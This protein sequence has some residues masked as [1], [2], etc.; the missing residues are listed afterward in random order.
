MKT[1]ITFFLIALLG[2]DFENPVSS[3]RF[4][5]FR[6]ITRTTAD[7]MILYRDAKDWDGLGKVGENAYDLITSREHE[8]TP[9]LAPVYPNPATL[10]DDMIK[11]PF[12]VIGS[13]QLL[14]LD[15]KG[16]LVKIIME[17]DFKLWGL[18]TWKL[19]QSD[20]PRPKKGYYE[21]ILKTNS[22]VIRGDVYL[23]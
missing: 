21:V 1:S 14:I 17:S 23:F 16:T 4:L 3:D 5:N 19:G 18:T 13:F 22:K 10:D 11:I 9:A 7:G 8:K 2:C 12:E 15:S 6:G 20:A